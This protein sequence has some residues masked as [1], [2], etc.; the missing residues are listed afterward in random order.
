MASRYPWTDRVLPILVS[1]TEQHR[2]NVNA[3]VEQVLA[4]GELPALL[5]LM[6]KVEAKSQKAKG[7]VGI[8]Y[9]FALLAMAE[10]IE[11]ALREEGGS[12]EQVGE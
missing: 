3:F 5:Q 10:R 1:L 4:E 2:A 7:P 11:Q 12:G 6:N 8:V 9:T